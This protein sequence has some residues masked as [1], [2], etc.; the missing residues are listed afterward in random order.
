MDICYDKR[1][2]LRHTDIGFCETCGNFTL[3]S[4]DAFVALH[5]WLNLIYEQIQ[6]HSWSQQFVSVV[7]LL[8]LLDMVDTF[9]SLDSNTRTIPTLLTI[10]VKKHRLCDWKT[11]QYIHHYST[12][13]LSCSSVSSNSSQ[14]IS[15]TLHINVSSG[16]VLNIESFLYCLQY[17]FILNRF[18]TEPYCNQLWFISGTYLRYFPPGPYAVVDVVLQR[19]DCITPESYEKFWKENFLL[20]GIHNLV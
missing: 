11:P 18:I 1:H 13:P 17:H 14:Q 4:C 7:T 3:K 5:I 10:F 20:L 9:T 2:A 6:R 12:V 19:R 8:Q 16:F 15:R